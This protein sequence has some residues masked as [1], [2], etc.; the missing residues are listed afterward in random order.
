MY[1]ANYCGIC[2][3][4]K[5]LYERIANRYHEKLGFAYAD[6]QECKL[7][8]LHVPL[9]TQIYKQKKVNEMDGVCVR[10]LKDF[11]KGAITI[12]DKDLR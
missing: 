11:V 9:F 7:D 6:V 1:T 4:I 10:T 5:P 2:N 8:L 12:T 3:E